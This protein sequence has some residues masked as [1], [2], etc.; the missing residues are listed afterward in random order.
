MCLW[1]KG[2]YIYTHTYIYMLYMLNNTSLN[3]FKR[4]FDMTAGNSRPSIEGYMDV[5]YC[6]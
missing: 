1:S 3:L 4:V 5:C 6:P 2:L